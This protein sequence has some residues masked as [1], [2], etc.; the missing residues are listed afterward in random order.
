MKRHEITRYETLVDRVNDQCFAYL[1]RELDRGRGEQEVTAEITSLALSLACSVVI[2]AKHGDEIE[3]HKT[4]SKLL[5]MILPDLIEQWEIKTGAELLVG[6]PLE[7][8][9]E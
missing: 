4:L 7:L 3:C 6:R 1:E 2:M 5:V 9:S 8:D